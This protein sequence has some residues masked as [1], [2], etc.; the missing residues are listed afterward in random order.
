M[1]VDAGPDDAAE[2]VVDDRL[3]GT[4]LGDDGLRRRGVLSGGAGLLRDGARMVM[5]VILRT[6]G[7]ADVFWA[8]FDIR[9]VGAYVRHF[10]LKRG[11]RHRRRKRGTNALLDRRG[12]A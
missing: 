5:G 10:K 12:V 11:V 3:V 8:W 1:R 7:T 9:C 4:R 2:G 6:N